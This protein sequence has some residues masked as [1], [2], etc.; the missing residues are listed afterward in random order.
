[1]CFFFSPKSLAQIPD[2]AIF[3]I[4]KIMLEKTPEGYPVVSA[5]CDVATLSND[6]VSNDGYIIVDYIKIIEEDIDTGIKTIIK[7][8]YFHGSGPL[9]TSQGGLY[10]RHPHWFIPNVSEPLNISNRENGLLTIAA[11]QRPDRISHFWT[12]WAE[13][14]LNVRHYVETRI[15]IS[16]D[17]GFQIGLDYCNNTYNCHPIGTH[18]EAFV[19]KWYGDTKGEFI[20]L[21]YPDYENRESLGENIMGLLLMEHFISQK[22]W[23]IIWGLITSS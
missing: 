8:E 17:I 5:R 23:L 13:S 1:M 11:G 18:R 3:P 12:Q 7:A 14:N 9:D 2:G 22:S 21:R 10:P 16:G 6:N 4:Q 15:K 20:T 19:S